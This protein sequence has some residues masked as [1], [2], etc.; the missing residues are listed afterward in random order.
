MAFNTFSPDSTHIQLAVC[1]L[2]PE[3]FVL[4]YWEF[5]TLLDKY[6]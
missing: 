6:V 2:T 3:F 1:P 4:G 5:H